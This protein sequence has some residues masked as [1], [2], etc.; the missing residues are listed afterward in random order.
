LEP[1]DP[2]CR[3]GRGVVADLEGIRDIERPHPLEVAEE[4]SVAGERL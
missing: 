1:I 2:E 4:A 3:A